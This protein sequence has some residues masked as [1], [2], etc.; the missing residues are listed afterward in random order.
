M[1]TQ[2][3]GAAAPMEGGSSEMAVAPPAG[4][5]DVEARWAMAEH[6]TARPEAEPEPGV[7]SRPMAPLAQTQ[8]QTTPGKWTAADFAQACA[9]R[10]SRCASQT[11]AA[12]PA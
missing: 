12:S 5:P 2:G 4:R 7:A 11:A 1:A 6:V 8:A 10:A 3:A 9:I